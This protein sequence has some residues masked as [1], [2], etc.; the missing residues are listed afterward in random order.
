M[1]A[2]GKSTLTASTLT[3]STLTASTLTT[4]NADGNQR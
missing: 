1:G 4:I 2:D 3:A